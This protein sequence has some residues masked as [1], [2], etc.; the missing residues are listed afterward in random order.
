M[1]L[2][3][4]SSTTLAVNTS[5]LLHCMHRAAS[6]AMPYQH[7]WLPKGQIWASIWCCSLCCPVPPFLRYFGNGEKLFGYC[8]LLC[9]PFLLPSLW[10]A[11]CCILQQCVVR[12]LFEVTAKNCSSSRWWPRPTPSTVFLLRGCCCLLMTSAMPRH[13]WH[14][15]MSIMLKSQTASYLHPHPRLHYKNSEINSVKHEKC[16]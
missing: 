1:E 11:L 16:S 12:E 14:S 4:I 3:A 5:Y 15:S 13:S 2:Q 7:C 9:P 6:L 10:P 8:C